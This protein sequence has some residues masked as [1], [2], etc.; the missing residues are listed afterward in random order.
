MSPMCLPG[1]RQCLLGLF[2]IAKTGS[3]VSCLALDRSTKQLS[4][5]CSLWWKQYIILV[6]IIAV[7]LM[8]LA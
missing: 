2:Q 4:S 3:A 6:D 8:K 1:I 7:F 5:C